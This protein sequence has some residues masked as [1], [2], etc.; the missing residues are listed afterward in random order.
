[1]I[2]RPPISTRTDTLFPYTTLF[3]SVD[4][5]EL[6]DGFGAL[7]QRDT[8]ILFL[9]LEIGELLLRSDPDHIAIAPL[10]ELFGAQHDVERLI[11]RHVLQAQGGIA[12]HRVGRDNRS[13]ERR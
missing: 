6:G 2:R 4:R 1:M 5:N 11:P 8:R 10:V 3:R 12:L 9:L 13:E 7:F